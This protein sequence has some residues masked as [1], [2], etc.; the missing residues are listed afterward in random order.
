MCSVQR[1]ILVRIDVLPPACEAQPVNTRS[2]NAAVGR[3]SPHVYS[4][5]PTPAYNTSL[6]TWSP[7]LLIGHVDAE[8]ARVVAS[9]FNSPCTARMTICIV[10]LAAGEGQDGCLRELHFPEHLWQKSRNDRVADTVHGV[11]FVVQCC[12]VPNAC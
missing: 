6:G 2:I 3:T 8:A 9:M 7:P 4:F 1:F 11:R 12:R 10:H 5:M